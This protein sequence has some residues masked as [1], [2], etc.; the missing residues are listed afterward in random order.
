MR[1]YFIRRFLLIPPTLLGISFVVFLVTRMAPGGPIEEA[2]MQM[3]QLS[4]DGGGG[5]TQ[6]GLLDEEQKKDLERY[7][8]LDKPIVQSYF[9]WLGLGP[10]EASHKE[11]EFASGETKGSVRIRLVEGEPKKKRMRLERDETDYVMITNANEF[12][13]N[14]NWRKLDPKPNAEKGSLRVE[15]FRKEYSGLL[16]GDLGRSFRYG[17]PVEQVIWQRLPVSTYFGVMTLLI[18]YAVCLPLGFYKAIRHNSWF[19][20]TTSVLIFMG[21]AIPGYVL[22]FLLI[23]FCAVNKEWFPTSGFTSINFDDLSIGEKLMDI[24]HHSVLPLCAYLVG[25]FAFVTM[26]MKNHLLDNLAA[27]YMRTALSK[28]VSYRAAVRR[29]AL[30]NSLIPIATNLG[31]QV[32]LFVT[33][34]FLIEKIFDINGFGLLGFNAIIDRD[35]PVVMGVLMLSAFLMLL[36]NVIS[37]FLMALVDPRVRFN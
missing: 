6:T 33:G 28:G 20:N 29:H 26:L 24:L 10:R 23:L 9:I 21:Y 31:H 15:V 13:G 37:D 11:V 36:G 12:S 16:Q 8:G 27:D 32:T 25:G 22:G 35:F 18:V 7:Y 19:D 4:E 5:Q 14:W 17:K 1:D 3:Q 34:S 30:R 2:M